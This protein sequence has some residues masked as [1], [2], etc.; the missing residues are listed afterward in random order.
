MFHHPVCV[1]DKCPVFSGHK[2]EQTFRRDRTDYSMQVSF[3]GI[4][5]VIGLIYNRQIVANF[6]LN[7]IKT[8][9]RWIRSGSNLHK[10]VGNVREGDSVVGSGVWWERGEIDWKRNIFFPNFTAN[11]QEANIWP[12]IVWSLFC[13]CKIGEIKKWPLSQ[14]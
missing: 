8:Q 2:M 3:D 12:S 13:I 10:N 11:V 14:H 4:L 7:S 6:G 9:W 1:G 5:S